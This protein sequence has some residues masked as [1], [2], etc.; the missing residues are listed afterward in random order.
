MDLNDEAEL[1]IGLLIALNRLLRELDL[2]EERLD[3]EE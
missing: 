2:E 1:V 3:A